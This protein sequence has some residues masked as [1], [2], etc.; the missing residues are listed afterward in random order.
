MGGDVQLLCGGKG[1][2]FRRKG[3]EPFAYELG[4][5]FL[6]SAAKFNETISGKTIRKQRL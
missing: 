5:L 1:V 4:D 3:G 2:F 6:L